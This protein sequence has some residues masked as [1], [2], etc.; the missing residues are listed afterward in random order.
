[1]PIL[2]AVVEDTASTPGRVHRAGLGERVDDLAAR[3]EYRDLEFK[4]PTVFPIVGVESVEHVVTTSDGG[5]RLTVGIEA[6]LG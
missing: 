5:N 3:A 6:D 1:M 2:P 4:L